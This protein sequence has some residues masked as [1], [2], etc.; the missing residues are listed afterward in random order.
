[1]KIYQ[2][3]GSVRDRILNK[4]SHDIDY[5]VVGATPEE[6]ISLGYKQVGKD[7]PVFLKN[8]MEYALARKE[9]KTGDKHTD[10]EF[11]F[12][13]D[14]TLEEDL[15]RRDFTINGLCFDEDGK[16]VDLVGGLQDLKDGIIRHI[17][18]NYFPQDPLRILRL[19]RF[20]SQLNFTVAPETIEIAK[21]MVANG[22]L[23]HLTP[24]RVWKEIQRACEYP[25]F[26]RFIEVLDE[27][28][29]LQVVL[30]EI[31]ALKNV[32]ERLDYHP[33]GNTYAHLM[34][35]LK[36][37][38]KGFNNTELLNFG[39]LCH[40]LGKLKTQET[41]PSHR[42]HEEY[43][44]EII[45]SLCD[46]LK[47]PNI[48]RKIAKLVC[49]HHMRF[50]EYQKSK[51]KTQYDFIQSTTG[52]KS[53]NRWKLNLLLNAH[54]CDL[55]GRDGEIAKD[56]IDNME[57]VKSLVCKQFRIL[58]DK[59]LEDMPVKDQEHLANFEKL[60]FKEQY[61]NV[62]INYLRAGLS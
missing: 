18:D 50:Y 24:E 48:Y 42:R 1:M 51:L 27:I 38:E 53:E 47:V 30:P 20:C 6:M 17:D 34:L 13:P 3:G 11:E 41:W 52:F 19:A 62:R 35:V 57:R 40:D 4:I 61:R 8:G 49:E 46:R 26:Y 59:T 10:F 37:V 31:Y 12:T 22:M 25:H 9:R 54:T 23:E 58:Q 16:V 2:V 29:A 21:K 7:F 44:I 60:E 5:V 55:M 15:R 56:R 32:P 14:I 33:E 28:N 39:L 36:Q 45:D 43:G